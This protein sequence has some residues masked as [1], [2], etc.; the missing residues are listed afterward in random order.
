[1]IQ[2]WAKDDSGRAFFTEFFLCELMV[3]SFGFGGDE[4]KQLGIN[5]EL[6][7]DTYRPDAS[8]MMRTIS[9]D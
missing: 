4:Y 8:N 3:S 6:L 9:L 5:A 7:A 2:A 1:M